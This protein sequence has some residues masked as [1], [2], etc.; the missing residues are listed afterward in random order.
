MK[1]CKLFFLWQIIFFCSANAQQPEE[2][3]EAPPVVIEYHNTDNQIYSHEQQGEPFYQQRKLDPLYKDNYKG[4]KFDYERIT[5][6][7]DP[8]PP[9]A[10]APLFSLPSGFMQILM[11]GILGIIILTIIYF[12]LKNAGGFSFGAEKR[13][14]QYDASEEKEEE[15]LENIENNNFQ[16]LIQKAKSEGDFRKAV[17]YY[18]LWVLQKL[19]DKRLI[20]WNKDKTDY[21]YFMELGQ[22]PIKEDFSNNTYIY[23]YTWYGNFHL[24][25][26]EFELAETIFQRTL[27]KLN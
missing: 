18:Y 24:N 19:T 23:D 5:P 27:S 7:K 2:V 17:R 25:Y 16:L 8:R 15:D 21:D 12:I 13:K 26:K 14:I 9:K 4:S 11:Y 1:R 20:N 10:T 6:K 22:H 3:R